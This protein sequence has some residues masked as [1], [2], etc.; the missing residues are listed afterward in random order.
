M[1]SVVTAPW[2]DLV[3]RA[4]D[5]RI[6]ALGISSPHAAATVSTVSGDGLRVWVVRDGSSVAVPVKC[7]GHV[8]PQPDDR[9]LMARVENPVARRRDDPSAGQEWCVIG[10]SSRVT[11]PGIPVSYNY[12]QVTGTNVSTSIVNLP[13]DPSF[14]WTKLFD[15]TDFT[16]FLSFTNYVTVNN[17]AVGGYLGFTKDGVQ[18]QYKMAEIESG[19]VA[20]RF[21]PK[22][23]RTIPD[24]VSPTPL[25]AG[26]YTVNLMWA[27]TQGPGTLNMTT[28]DDHASAL[29][30]ELGA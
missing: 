12:A 10:V 2:E 8:R 14:S 17:A 7:L 19:S 16:A 29:V 9:V 1:D 24:G 21:G 28:A 20:A 23:W 26:Q 15:D 27:R 30:W 22:H 6:A 18:T 25:A 4:I 3:L 11:A 5:E 13:G